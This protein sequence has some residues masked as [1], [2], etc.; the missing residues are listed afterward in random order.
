MD[1]QILKACATGWQVKQEQKYKVFREAWASWFISS[2]VF[3]TC[4]FFVV[5]S[6]K[7]VCSST[8]TEDHAL[9]VVLMIAFPTAI[10]MRWLLKACMLPQYILS[11]NN[12]FRY[13]EAMYFIVFGLGYVQSDLIIH[14]KVMMPL[15]DVGL[16]LVDGII[17][18]VTAPQ[19]LAFSPLKLVSMYYAVTA[20]QGCNMVA[21][22]H[23]PGAQVSDIQACN[24]PGD[25]SATQWLQ[26]FGSTI[27]FLV[28]SFGH[29]YLCRKAFLNKQT[30]SVEAMLSRTSSLNPG[31]VC[32]LV[33]AGSD[34]AGPSCMAAT[35][36][37]TITANPGK[38]S[39]LPSIMAAQEGPSAMAASAIP[40]TKD[41]PAEP[42]VVPSIMAAQEGPSA[43]AASVI[44][45]ITAN[46]A[47]PPTVAA[48]AA[49]A[50]EPRGGAFVGELRGG[51]I[52][53][54]NQEGSCIL[55]QAT[56][57]PKQA[58]NYSQ[59][60]HYGK[61][62]SGYVAHAEGGQSTKG[63]RKPS[64]SVCI[65]ECFFGFA[66]SAMEMQWAGPIGS[67]GHLLGFTF[68]TAVGNFAWYIRFKHGL[69]SALIWMAMVPSWV[70]RSPTVVYT[71]PLQLSL[72]IVTMMRLRTAR[73][74]GDIVFKGVTSTEFVPVLDF[75]LG[76][77][78]LE[79]G[80]DI[81]VTIQ[82]LDV[83][84][85]VFF[86]PGIYTPNISSFQI[87][88]A[89]GV[90]S[91]NSLLIANST[92]TTDCETVSLF[93]EEIG[94][95][96]LHS[97]GTRT[98]SRTAA[99]SSSPRQKQHPPQT[100][101]LAYTQA[102]PAGDVTSVFI[103]NFVNGI[104]SLKNVE[105]K[106]DGYPSVGHPLGVVFSAKQLH[107]TL[108]TMSEIDEQVIVEIFRNLQ[109][110]LDWT[111]VPIRSNA[112]THI[113]GPQNRTV[114]WDLSSL[115]LVLANNGSLQLSNLV[116]INSCVTLFRRDAL[117]PNERTLLASVLF[118]VS[119]QGVTLNDSTINNTVVVVK[120]YDL[121]YYTYWGLVLLSPFQ[122][123]ESL[124]YFLLV[125]GFQR[126][127]FVDSPQ[128]NR[129]AISEFSSSIG[130]DMKN[131]TFVT[132]IP[133]DAP[134]GFH[135][136]PA[137]FCES[138]T[139]ANEANQTNLGMFWAASTTELTAH[140]RTVS[141]NSSDSL[142]SK[143]YP[144]VILISG[145][146]SLVAGHPT[147]VDAVQFTQCPK[148][149]PVENI[150]TRGGNP[151]SV[152]L[153]L[154]NGIDLLS[155]QRS[156][157]TF[158]YLQRVTLVN[159]IPK[160]VIASS[161]RPSY[162][163]SVTQISGLP[164]W[165]FKLSEQRL[166]PQLLLDSVTLVLVPPDF[167][168]IY[169]AAQRGA[170]WKSGSKSTETLILQTMVFDV[171]QVDEKGILF[172]AYVGWGLNASNFLLVPS[173][174]VD[175]G[176]LGN[177]TLQP[178]ANDPG[179]TDAGSSSSVA[180]AVGLGVG[181]GVLLSLIV[182]DQELT[183]SNPGNRVNP[184]EK[185]SEHAHN[186]GPGMQKGLNPGVMTMWQQ[187]YETPINMNNSRDFVRNPGS[188]GP[189]SS[190]TVQAD[191]ALVSDPTIPSQASNLNGAS[192]TQDGLP[193]P[194]PPP[195][196]DPRKEVA[197]LV[198][199]LSS[200]GDKLTLLEAIGQGG[201][202][203]VYRGRWRNL[204]VAVKTVLFSE[205]V[206]TKGRATAQPHQRAIL[207]AAVCSTV[208]HPN[209]VI[210][211]HYEAAVCSTVIHPNVVTTY[212]YEAAVCSTVI[213]PNLVIT[214]R[215]VA[216]VCSTAINP[217]VVTT[218]R[219]GALALSFS[220]ASA[221]FVSLPPYIPASPASLFPLFFFSILEAAVCSTA[222][223][224]NVVIT[225]RYGALA[226]SSSSA[227]AFASQWHPSFFLF[228]FAIP[229]AAVCSTV[230]HPNVVT[231][232][233]YEA[234]VCSTV[235]HPNV[236]IT[237]N[238]G[239]LAL[240]KSP[241]PLFATLEAAVCSNAIHPIVV[242]VMV[243]TYNYEAAVC[244]TAIHPNVVITYRIGTL[245]LS[246]ASASASYWHPFFSLFFFT[247]LE[248]AV[249]STAI[250]PNVVITYRIEA[251]VCSTA[252][253]PN[254]V[255]TYRYE[256]SVCSTAIHP[257]VVITYRY[258]ISPIQKGTTGLNGLT[259]DE[260]MGNTDWKLYL[261][262]EYCHASMQ[263]ALRN[264]LLHD[265]NTMAPD[266]DA[267]SN[268]LLHD[269]NTMAPDM[270][271]VLTVILTIVRDIPFVLS[272]LFVRLHYS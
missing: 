239:K 20:I 9:P 62:L 173:S 179:H 245:A 35:I 137:Q 225:Y 97:T 138:G 100:R 81:K 93:S 268:Y 113:Q 95:G 153:D 168:Q 269:N 174:P 263:D 46:P 31:S 211:Y 82:D 50:E 115:P 253:H 118:G 59:N 126:M 255:T 188:S 53:D 63:V 209:V 141:V 48:A 258:D 128:P 99:A 125:A 223:H 266:M 103:N 249:C 200:E 69:L 199:D 14:K 167:L 195:A 19:A 161:N 88:A 242:M 123:L 206:Q 38:P 244:S 1:T 158:L 169:Y 107:S 119:F 204:E 129:L 102:V 248:A 220:S 26:I 109:L 117:H 108:L 147:N 92:V 32:G 160:E 240:N 12:A 176:P 214:Y 236:V 94:L 6:I 106:C 130:S 162:D 219:Y 131:V 52:L 264:Y 198:E 197:Q 87:P 24:W 170:A 58:R 164:L 114:Y 16:A 171:I 84:G 235:I 144:P 55:S 166:T 51:K 61:P 207:E 25:L 210:T 183:K 70:A 127:V 180:L 217:N 262:Q 142:F 145:N 182:G 192:D 111:P 238:Y 202:G 78:L 36:I 159:V 21:V 154:M 37:P 101:T 184:R 230:I 251:A 196:F 201:F 110:P 120:D 66:D 29:E 44:P 8:P 23:T 177:I 75:R 181:L 143:S 233:H 86:E 205:S 237:Y 122:R 90:N 234:A 132:E 65:G 216:A 226:I 104:F 43:M 155:V 146:A 34:L 250:H 241:Y 208:I 85:V 224:P 33:T 270:D 218:Y 18:Q 203:T 189:G 13:F 73:E 228:F 22:S 185:S 116:I 231:T 187:L 163:S 89:F 232:Y 76:V 157:Y 165:A 3:M 152:M 27:A 261:V 41:G 5:T 257:N 2:S 7:M 190:N 124:S 57:L 98:S 193:T 136:K 30:L 267:V 11:I 39:A 247:T 139:L 10:A 213:H 252:I 212:H 79:L 259:I 148:T 222:I 49:T 229:E 77:S 172:N 151:T 60:V 42:S 56:V 72:F 272:V 254:V 243:V 149:G 186:W 91:T 134:P 74:Q 265:K 54:L 194:S 175:P 17:L 256:A 71:W 68:M 150:G 121:K 227:S 133:A 80:A 271:L 28:V 45:Y 67:T 15:I 140:L 105:L 112:G 156:Q 64:L 215:Y 40:Y 178:P 4:L 246:F 47:I 135:W 96:S 83:Q 260:S 191:K 221:S